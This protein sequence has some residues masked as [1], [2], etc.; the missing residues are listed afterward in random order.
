MNTLRNWCALA[1]GLALCGS[2]A[3][4]AQVLMQPT[5]PPTESAALAAWFVA[6]EPVAW[7]G[8]VF[9]QAGPQVFFNGNTMV[10]VGWFEGTPLYADT[11]IEPNS[12]VL[13]PV[14]GRMMQPYERVRE[15][16]VAG[17][18]GS[19]APSFP[20]Q[21][22]T[23]LPSGATASL[24]GPWGLNEMA[25]AAGPPVSWETAGYQSLLGRVSTDREVAGAA[26]GAPRP[27]GTVGTSAVAARVEPA[28]PLF[29]P[30]AASTVRA[31][32]E[33]LG[34][35]IDYEGA[36]YQACGSAEP[37]A[38]E[39]FKQTGTY[40][41]FPVFSPVGAG[42]GDRI[43]LPSR[44]GL[45]APYVRGPVTLKPGGGCTAPTAG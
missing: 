20:V 28:P 3:A 5:E 23:A 42:T 15:F 35:W 22:A 9:H 8:I 44:T 43:Y 39:R 36:R 1:I 45:V 13:V 32:D 14:G 27:V 12:I 24:V 33:T 18:T 2:A 41:G 10:R 11:T 25:M 40:R 4:G 21:P 29:T 38:V 17:T 30:G 6:D 16:D 34:I 31:A 37:L 19:R 7:N 26:T